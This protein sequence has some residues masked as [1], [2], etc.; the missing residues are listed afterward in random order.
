MADFVQCFSCIFL[1]H[2][3]ICGDTTIRLS[4]CTENFLVCA[5][6]KYYYVGMWISLLDT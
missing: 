5:M 4:D 1:I 6:V 3:V 2:S